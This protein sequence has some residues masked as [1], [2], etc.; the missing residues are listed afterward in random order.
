MLFVRTRADG[1]ARG[2]QMSRESRAQ[3]FYH[4]AGRVTSARGLLPP[5]DK[6]AFGAPRAE[7]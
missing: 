1:A 4:K 7:V 2:G 6:V 3:Y 5:G